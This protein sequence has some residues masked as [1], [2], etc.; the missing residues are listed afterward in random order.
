MKTI[1]TCDVFNNKQVVSLLASIFSFFSVHFF[2]ASSLFFLSVSPVATDAMSGVSMTINTRKYDLRHT[3]RNG[4]C[5]L[6][7]SYIRSSLLCR[8]QNLP[9]SENSCS[10]FPGLSSHA[11]PVR[12]RLLQERHKRRRKDS[13]RRKLEFTKNWE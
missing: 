4:K 5:Q 6:Q 9:R 2:L 8:E 13:G 11:T 3:L 12:D 1:I 7:T 10:G